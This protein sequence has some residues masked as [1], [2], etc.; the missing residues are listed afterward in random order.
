VSANSQKELK[1]PAYGGQAVIEGVMMRG[2]RFLAMA[3]RDHEG[4]IQI[5]EEKLPGIYSSKWMR[6]PFLRGVLG[7]WDSL[8]LGTRMISLSA[9]MSG[10]DD[11][12]IDNKSMAFVSF[13][14]LLIG[15]AVFFLLPAFVAGLLDKAWSLGA[16]WSNI[17]EGILRL[18]ILIAYMF[19]VGQIP[20]IKRVYAYHGAE[21]KTINAFEENAELVPSEVARQSTQHPR[22]GTSFMLTLAV[23]SVLV[24]S[25]LGP[26]PIYW[27]LIS[28]VL[29]LPVVAGIAYEYIRW[30]AGMMD[31]SAFLRWIIKPNLALQKL[32]TREPSEDM[33]EVSLAAFKRLLELEEDPN[34]TASE[35]EP[36]PE[37]AA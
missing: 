22:C 4:H 30:V 27:R 26:M 25:V 35:Q 21:H 2:K 19:L 28:R 32:T 9:N 12:Q 11:E 37:L 13:L 23:I 20:D 14:S 15:V 24:F 31:R 10:T 34:G 33:L 36:Q 16:W 1:M 7:L 18:F 3:V 6:I 8:S 29:M 17:I 5:H